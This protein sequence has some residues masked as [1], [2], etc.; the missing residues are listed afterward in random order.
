MNRLILIAGAAMLVSAA[1]ATAGSNG[2][3]GGNLQGG[4]TGTINSLLGGTVQS[5]SGTSTGTTGAGLSN[6]LCQALGG[7][8]GLGGLVSGGNGAGGASIF[9][10]LPTGILGSSGAGDGHDGGGDH[11]SP[12]QAIGL[13][14]I[15]VGS[16]N[17]STLFNNGNGQHG[18]TLVKVTALNATAGTAGRVANVAIL[19][20]TGSHGPSVVNVSLLNG[21]ANGGNGNGNSNGNG[22]GNGALP[23][24]I[25]LINGVPC[26]PDG[27][28]LTGA[29]AT[30]ALAALAPS[31]SNGGYGSAGPN[32][33]PSSPSGAGQNHPVHDRDRTDR[34]DLWWPAHTTNQNRQGR[35]NDH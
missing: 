12:G 17:G 26:L 27:T 5:T 34:K 11:H 23:G 22:N 4:L 2:G 3:S 21:T 20:G 9:G 1:P 10:S 16:V 6:C 25:R 30:A 24:G 13:A 31:G 8:I 7:P 18:E 32:D 35:L 33:Q 28:P 29:A 14:G 19:N 15:V